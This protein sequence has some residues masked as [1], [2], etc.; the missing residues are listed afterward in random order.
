MKNESP[1]LFNLLPE[2][3]KSQLSDGLTLE[4]FNKMDPLGVQD[5]YINR[6][7][8]SK[9]LSNAPDI[10]IGN[11]KRGSAPAIGD[12]S[13]YVVKG[14]N[15]KWNADLTAQNIIGDFENLLSGEKGSMVNGNVNKEELGKVITKYQAAGQTDRAGVAELMLDN[16]D[17]FKN[18]NG[19]IDVSSAAKGLKTTVINGKSPWE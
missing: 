16:Y 2:N 5:G 11:R 4:L 3:I 14:P 9:Y 19:D 1:E 13:A 7:E 18:K 8:F 12:G 15:G 17:A 6:E 10:N